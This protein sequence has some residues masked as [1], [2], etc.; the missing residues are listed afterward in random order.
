MH[1]KL[2]LDI[3]DFPDPSITLDALIGFQVL[4]DGSVLPYYNKFSVSV[5]WPWYVKVISG[6]VTGIVGHFIGDTIGPVILDDR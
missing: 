6:A 3:N 4:A 2:G 5:D 1:L